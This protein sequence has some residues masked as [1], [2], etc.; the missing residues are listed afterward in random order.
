M[1]A[2]SGDYIVHDI[3]NNFIDPGDFLYYQPR[4][5]FITPKKSADP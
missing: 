3:F 4:P 5:K 2:G 1:K